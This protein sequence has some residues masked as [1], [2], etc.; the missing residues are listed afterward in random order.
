MIR[1]ND[2]N[3]IERNR[4]LS[5]CLLQTGILSNPPVAV[6][7]TQRKSV[8]NYDR[9]SCG[10]CFCRINNSWYRKEK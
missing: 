7:I 6:E 1:T 2:K 3:V 4:E 5:V 8:K 10:N 9:L